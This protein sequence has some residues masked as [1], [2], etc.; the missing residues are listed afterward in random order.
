LGVDLSPGGLVTTLKSRAL[1]L[2]ADRDALRA[3]AEDVTKLYDEIISRDDTIERLKALAAKSQALALKADVYE[4]A[5]HEIVAKHGRG[6]LN[7]ARQAL[8]S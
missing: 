5:L 2:A 3:Q 7:I 4:A 1:A 6:G 8:D